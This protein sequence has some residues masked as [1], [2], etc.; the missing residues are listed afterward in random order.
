VLL[1]KMVAA[2]TADK[3]ALGKLGQASGTAV[4]M[5]QDQ[6]KKAADYVGANWSIELP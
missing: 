3:E 6:A 5:T 1:D 4:V 2:G